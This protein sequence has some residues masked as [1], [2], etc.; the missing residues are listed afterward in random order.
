MTRVYATNCR[1]G[2]YLWKVLLHLH[3]E[4]KKVDKFHNNYIPT[5]RAQ[6]GEIKLS[7]K[8]YLAQYT[9]YVVVE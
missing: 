1:V 8:R 4:M 3:E 9:P 2:R 6:L 7:T 5:L